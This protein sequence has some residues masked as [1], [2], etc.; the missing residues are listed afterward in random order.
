MELLLRLEFELL[1]S[2]FQEVVLFLWT[3]LLEGLEE[4]APHQKKI[5]LANLN[6]KKKSISD[7]KLTFGNVIG[8]ID[9]HCGALRHVGTD[10]IRHSANITGVD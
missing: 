1:W 4:M 10:Q 9:V 7:R 8:E 3:L 6:F 2:P 5:H